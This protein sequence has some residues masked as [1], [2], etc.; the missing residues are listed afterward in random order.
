VA[1][2]SDLLGSEGQESGSQNRGGR[3]AAFPKD[4]GGF[5]EPARDDL[6]QQREGLQFGAGECF[7]ELPQGIRRRS[8]RLWC[9][10]HAP[11]MG[12]LRSGTELDRRLLCA[13]RTGE[14][15]IDAFLRTGAVDAK[16]DLLEERGERR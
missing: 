2:A 8:V 7:V 10:E 16:D 11:I 3:E 5:A 12:A 15:R 6:G 14:S 1:S 9:G 13:F 4:R